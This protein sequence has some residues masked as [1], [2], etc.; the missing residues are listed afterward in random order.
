M[1]ITDRDQQLFDF[2]LTLTPVKRSNICS[3]YFHPGATIV[4]LCEK[5]FEKSR[6][7]HK[8]MM[9]QWMTYFSRTD[10]RVQKMA[11]SCL[12]SKSAE[13]IFWALRVFAYCQIDSI[14]P[15]IQQM[16]MDEREKIRI[17]A[18]YAIRSIRNRNH[19]DY[20]P[21]GKWYPSNME[22]NHDRYYDMGLITREEDVNTYIVKQ[23]KPEELEKLKM[24]VGDIYKR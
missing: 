20:Q 14:L 7:P 19:L 13:L 6:T 15:K 16:T 3:L 2:L 11:E 5:I 18:G 10:V 24:I 21:P 23:L 17:D 4:D 9:L 12:D 1:E 22:N 8:V